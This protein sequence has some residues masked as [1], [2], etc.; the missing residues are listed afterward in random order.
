MM[1]QI[2]R[3]GRGETAG[4]TQTA[5]KN[6]RRARNE[7]RAFYLFVAPWLLGFLGL[8]LFPLILG[9]A[10]SFTN[11]DGLNLDSVRFMGAR[12]YTR[13]IDTPDFWLAMRNTFVYALISVPL[14]LAFGLFLAMLL[15]LKIA[16]RSFFRMLYYL[17]S[18]LPLAGAV[19]AWSLLFNPNTGL[20]NAILSYI[21]PGTA[22]NWPRDY[23]F[24]MLYL[25]SLWHVGGSMVL[26]LA[27]LQGIPTDLYE[28]GRI[29]GANGWQ[30]FARITMPLLTPVIFFQTILGIIG[31]L[32]ILDVAILLYGRAGLSGAVQM[33][34]DKY[35][36]M[37]Y[38]YIQV[39]DFQRYGYGVALSWIFFVIVLI[40]TLVVLVSS[41][42]WVYY[43]VAQEGDG[44]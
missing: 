13:A 21:W 26:F 15:N 44:R 24:P 37:V 32:Q 34:R 38:N 8:S 18:I 4:R 33:P 16:G 40:L 6:S 22:I 1:Q 20:V 29:D 11:Y 31:S 41:R 42:Y 7:A 35:L 27:G 2:L 28:A 36:Y 43:E 25:Y 14:G 23:F 17:P 19:V 10:T 3:F 12:N 5:P 9:L 30:L 39:F